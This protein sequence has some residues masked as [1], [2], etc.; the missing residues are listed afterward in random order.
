M[1]RELLAVFAAIVLSSTA[2]PAARAQTDPLGTLDHLLCFKI[3]DALTLSTSVDMMADLQPDFAAKGCKLTKPIEF[4]V[5]ASKRNVAPAPADPTQF[6]Q[7]L[8]DDY[9]CYKA[10]CSDIPPPADRL[11]VDQFGHRPIA[12]FRAA[13]VCV[14]ARKEPLACGP[15]GGKS[16]GG[17]CPSADQKCLYDKVTNMCGCTPA[18]CDGKPDKAGMCGGTCPGG[19]PLQCRP[20]ANKRCVCQPPPPPQ[21]AAIP[22]TV[23]LCGGSCPNPADVCRPGGA[24]VGCTCQPP[25]DVCGLDAS[26]GQCGG[27]CA[28]PAEVCRSGPFG[29]CSCQAQPLG[30]INTF[31]GVANAA[32]TVLQP[33][34][35]ENGIAVYQPPVGPPFWL[36]AEFDRSTMPSSIGE[37]GT[38]G[39]EVMGAT[40]PD[41]EVRVGMAIGT[42]AGLGSAQVCD[43]GVPTGEAIGGVPVSVDFS[44]TPALQDFACRFDVRDTSDTAC[45]MNS[46][47]NFDFAAPTTEK[48]FCALIDDS[49]MF[50]SGDTD[51]EARAADNSGVFGPSGHI[52]IRRP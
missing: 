11:A 40:L 43:D 15:T 9:I 13:K 22:A 8:R 45:T 19:V 48:Q 2:L 1:P 30:P 33:V 24:G 50:Q 25:S 31:L 16:C 26:S 21:C 37:Q 10:E 35:V 23:P 34:A 46:L 47:G 28:S 49:L 6:G 32:G 42:G 27:A 44:N 7:S 14:P 17:L 20:D 4:C 18:P 51:V 36:F 5:P 38:K 3:K 29:A 39:Q 41:L 12:K 52:I